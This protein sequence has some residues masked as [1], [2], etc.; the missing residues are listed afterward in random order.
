MVDYINEEYCDFSN[1]ASAS[2]FGWD[3]QY[4]AGIFLFLKYIKNATDI[5]IESKLQD[6][7]ITLSNGSKILAQAKS[8]QDY[9]IASDK[10]EKFKDAIISLSRISK[11]NNQLIYISNIPDTFKTAV[12]VFNNSVVSYDKCLME[13]RKEIDDVFQSVILSIEN[14]ILK[15][16]K[17]TK[18]KKLLTIKKGV[19]KFDKSSLFISTINPY[20]GD[21]ETRYMKIGDAV[22]SFLV[23]TIKLN[24]DDAISIKQRLLEHWQLS[25]EYNSTVKDKADIKKVTKAKF[26]WPIAVFLIDNDLSEIIDCLSFTPDKAITNNV[27]RIMKDSKSIYHE[28]FEFSNKV[29]QEFE[30]FKKEIY[31]KRVT[32]VEKEFINKHGLEFIKEFSF[33]QDDDVVE[34]LTKAFV[35]RIISNNR[36]MRKISVGVG[37]KI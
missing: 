9:T 1:D 36:N 11:N 25:F 24:R 4:N 18:K 3:F 2:S 12:D 35:Y 8:A 17:E 6:I 20:F 21:E 27:Q 37:M 23:D 19:E 33:I 16:N 31:G 34:Y 5:K 29:L 15:E 26:A 28:R 30:K 14:K 10:K 32:Q 22:L 13:T 7:E